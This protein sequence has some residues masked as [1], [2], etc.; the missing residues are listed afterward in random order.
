MDDIV[1]TGSSSSTVQLL[2]TTLT[3][4]FG[5]RISA[6]FPSFW[7]L[8]SADSLLV[9]F[10]PKRSMFMIYGIALKCSLLSPFPLLWLLT[11]SSLPTLVIS[12]R[13]RL[14]I[15]A[16]LEAFDTSPS[17]V[18]TLLLLL[19][20]YANLCILPGFPIGKRLNAFCVIYVIPHT[21]VFIFAPLV[22]P[23]SLPFRMLTGLAVPMIAVQRVATMCSSATT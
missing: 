13:T 20:R 2:I 17:H 19:V 18:L 15:A 16:S 9:I 5:S 12:I 8:R 10:F 6:I 23:H 7:V 22:P 3:L 21:M 1:I 11:L 14:V 4:I